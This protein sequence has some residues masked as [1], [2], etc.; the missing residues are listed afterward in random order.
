MVGEY[1][2]VCG[3]CGKEAV[4]VGVGVGRMRRY[5]G[6]LCKR[7]MRRASSRRTY[8]AHRDRVGSLERAVADAGIEVTDG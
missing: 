8:R 7:A 2:I 5:C 3:W 6:D 4:L 1:Q